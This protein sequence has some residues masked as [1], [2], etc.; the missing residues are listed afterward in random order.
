ME[1]EVPTLRNLISIRGSS[2]EVSCC[3]RG[4]RQLDPRRGALTCLWVVL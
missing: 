1:A 2:S 4:A 3:E